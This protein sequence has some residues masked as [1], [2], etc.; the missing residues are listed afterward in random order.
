MGVSGHLVRRSAE[1]V[2]NFQDKPAMKVEFAPWLI[3][4]LVALFLVFGLVLL[5]I[6]YT[7]AG[8]VATLAAIEDSNPDIYVRIDQHDANK[9]YDPNEPEAAGSPRPKPITSG[10]RSTTRHL[11]SRAG[12]WSRFR[13]LS[14]YLAYVLAD[15]FLSLVFPISTNSFFGQ[16]FVQFAISML[17][18]TWHM[19]WVHIVISEPSPK[20]F[21]QRIPSYRK[22]IRIAPAV[23]LQSA[24]TYASFLL[25]M[26]VAQFAG[27]T[28]VTEDPNHP[29]QTINKSL[30]RFLAI[31]TLPALLALAVSVPANVIF[32]RVAA[33]MLPEED[34]TI[35][36]FDRSFGG[37]VQPEIVGGSGKIGLMDA[38]TTFDWSARVRFVKIVIKTILIQVAV[39]FVG[40]SLIM[41]T[42]WGLSSKG[43]T[44]VPADGSL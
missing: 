32:V 11:R 38:W 20:R 28:D 40:I 41:A 19:A 44:M 18:A 7:Y 22:W 21:Y 39:M 12:F 9:P 5:A 35:V 31:S 1:F 8:V 27:W 26:A 4:L 36:P 6:D 24:L 43:M 13:G 17:L 2:A 23:A 42:A 15:A 10:L 30:L 3:C 16:L 33:S 29:E 14:I 34:E 25:P 37:K